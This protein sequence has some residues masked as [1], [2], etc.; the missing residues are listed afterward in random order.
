M[1]HA[2]KASLLQAKSKE[3]ESLN[4]VMDRYMMG[5]GKADVKTEAECGKAQMDNLILENGKME[6]L[7]ALVFL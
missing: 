6:K 7:K 2:L 3:E 5:N 4:G 1:D